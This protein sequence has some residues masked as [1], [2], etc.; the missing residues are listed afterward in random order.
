MV[1]PRRAMRS[2]HM[3][4]TQYMSSETSIGGISTCLPVAPGFVGMNMLARTEQ[5][6]LRLHLLY[7]FRVMSPIENHLIIPR[8]TPE[9]RTETKAMASSVLSTPE[10]RE[11]TR[12]MEASWLLYPYP[13]W[14]ED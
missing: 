6:D 11:E 9:I 8:E 4:S 14:S 10:I 12:T 3:A 1:A 5:H 7:I 2:I 13:S